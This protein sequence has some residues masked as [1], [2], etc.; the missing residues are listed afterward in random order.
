VSPR[1]HLPS[2]WGRRERQDRLP[3]ETPVDTRLIAI[4]A[5]VIAVIVLILVL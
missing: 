1:V 3:E 2:R 5:L 4:L